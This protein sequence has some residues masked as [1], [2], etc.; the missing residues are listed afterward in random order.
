LIERIEREREE[1]AKAVCE[2]RDFSR[3]ARRLEALSRLLLESESRT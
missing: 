1:V 2:H 3:A